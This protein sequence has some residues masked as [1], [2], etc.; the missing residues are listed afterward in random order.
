MS[1]EDGASEQPADK[2]NN[3]YS[4]EFKFNH[5]IKNIKAENSGCRKEY[6]MPALKKR[7]FK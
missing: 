4:N 5:R 1:A 3:R 7:A 2:N 6:D